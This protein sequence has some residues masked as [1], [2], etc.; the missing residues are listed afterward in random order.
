MKNLFR[1]FPLFEWS[2]KTA[3]LWTNLASKN[4]FQAKMFHFTMHLRHFETCLNDIWTRETLWDITMCVLTSWDILRCWIPMFD[5]GNVHGAAMFACHT[6]PWARGT[7]CSRAGSRG[8]ACLSPFGHIILLHP[9]VDF[10]LDNPWQNGPPWVCANGC[11]FC[12]WDENGTW[13]KNCREMFMTEGCF[14]HEWYKKAGRRSSNVFLSRHDSIRSCGR[15]FVSF[16]FPTIKCRH[17]H[18]TA[19]SW[20]R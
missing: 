10:I 13:K 19:L 9:T 17:H 5:V 15:S 2:L 20:W 8:S 6:A 18:A 1:C 4:S 12:H 11:W 16:F 3:L 14:T 7:T